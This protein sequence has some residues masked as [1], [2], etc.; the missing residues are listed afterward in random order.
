MKIQR[1]RIKGF[2]VFKEAEIQNLSN[3]SVFLGANGSGK[4]SLFD[5]LS[6]LSDAVKEDAASAVSRRGGFKEIVSK[7]QTDDITFEIG[8]QNHDTN[9]TYT[10]SVGLDKNHPVVKKEVLRADACELMNFNKGEGI[11]VSNEEEYEAGKPKKT[12]EQLLDAPDILALK[13]LGQFR[14]F[15]TASSLRKLLEKWHVLD[16]DIHE[17]RLTRRSLADGHLTSTGDN[18]AYVAQYIYQN[19]PAIFDEILGKMRKQIPEFSDIEPVETVDR[20][21]ILQFKDRKF[22][23]PFPPRHVSDGT[24]K[25]FAYLLLLHDPRPYPLLC[26]EEPENHL[27]PDL[28]PELAEEFREY[29]NRGGQVFV[30]THSP[31]FVNALKVEELSWLTRK[32]GFSKVSHAEDD[33]VIRALCEAGDPLGALWTQ[34]YL[35]GGGIR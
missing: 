4:S 6:F 9:V 27:H 23:T 33:P 22:G 1:I 17:V 13:G 20:R 21:V 12:E 25:L 26:V 5:A 35:K 30:S 18:L 14:R 8:F 11:A 7:G 32:E 16:F 29:A 3:P 10:L 2:K 15:K 19:H 28:L 31:E 34:N 24:L